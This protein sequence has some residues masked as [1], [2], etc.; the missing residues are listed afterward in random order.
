MMLHWMEGIRWISQSFP[1][2]VAGTVMFKGEVHD[3]QQGKKGGVVVPV[4]S[5]PF[6]GE[7][8]PEEMLKLCLWA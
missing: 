6:S 3:Q 2:E 7:L 1:L 5:R 4:L 8:F